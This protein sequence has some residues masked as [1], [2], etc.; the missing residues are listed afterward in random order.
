MGTKIG[1]LAVRRS[2][3]IAATS[4]RVWQ[5]FESHDRMKA[6]FGTGH[7]VTAYEPRLGG[8]V[9]TDSGHSR[10]HGEPLRFG[11]K[12]VV[13]DPPHQVTWENDWFGHGWVAPSLMTFRLTPAEG[14]TVVELFHHGFERT[15]E[16]LTET[17]NGFE[18][19]WTLRQLEA[20]R[21]LVE[22]KPQLVEA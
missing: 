21:Q 16:S 4:E 20:L 2:I 9:E 6:W 15:G 3:W 10:E 11:G 7:S 22:A 19:G 5:E 13:W 14:G 8:Y 1:P 18:A 17:L 12:I